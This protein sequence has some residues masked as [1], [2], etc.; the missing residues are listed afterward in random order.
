MEIRLRDRL[1]KEQMFSIA[2]LT[3]VAV[4]ISSLIVF[5]W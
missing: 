4:I 5:G 3:G 2:T 1:S